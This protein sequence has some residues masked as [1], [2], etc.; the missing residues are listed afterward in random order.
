MVII[1]TIFYIVI[2]NGQNFSL[3]LFW[4]INIINWNCF[5]SGLRRLFPFRPFFRNTWPTIDLWPEL[6]LCSF[7]REEMVFGTRLFFFF[8]Y[9]SHHMLFVFTLEFLLFIFFI[10]GFFSVLYYYDWLMCISAFDFFS[11]FPCLFY[12]YYNDFLG[13]IFYNINSCFTYNNILSIWQ[14]ILLFG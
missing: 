8:G 9:G 3:F 5:F 10:D 13:N 1:V 11:L 14:Q 12:L 7:E 6:S 4:F 2:S